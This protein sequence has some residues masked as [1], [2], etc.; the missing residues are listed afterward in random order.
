MIIPGLDGK[1]THYIKR[2]FP[3]LFELIIDRM[4]L[5]AQKQIN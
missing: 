5:K 3:G 2:W 4:V 1:I